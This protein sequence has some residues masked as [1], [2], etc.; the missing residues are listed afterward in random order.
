MSKHLQFGQPF[1]ILGITFGLPGIQVAVFIIPSLKAKN[2]VKL[3]QKHGPC[4]GL[5]ALD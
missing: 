1:L 4:S 2:Y 5:A 3:R